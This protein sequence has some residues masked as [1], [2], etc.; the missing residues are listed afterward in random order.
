MLGY[1]TARQQRKLDEADDLMRAE[2]YRKAEVIARDVI[3]QSPKNV[4]ARKLLVTLYMEQGEIEQAIQEIR[5]ILQLNPQEK[6]TLTELAMLLIERRKYAESETVIDQAL[7]VAPKDVSLLRMQGELRERR[8]SDS[9]AL[10]SY[11]R[12]LS[13]NPDDSETIL[14]IAKIE[15][16]HGREEMAIILLRKVVNT[17]YTSTDL[18]T[19]AKLHLTEAYESLGRWSDATLVLSELVRSS[20][21]TPD[22]RYRYAHAL[23]RDG[24]APE[25]KQALS[26]FLAQSPGDPRGEELAEK[27]SPST[28][29]SLATR[30]EAVLPAGH[31]RIR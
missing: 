28:T 9:E 5:R 6:E 29:R 25:G 2:K 20:A 13:I 18:Q 17:S 14:K 27:F 10:S 1:T 26:E 31:S 16:R 24:R 4:D 7:S 12:I 30:A 23:F 21:A 3:R 8:G 11:Y 22:L 15:V 19:E